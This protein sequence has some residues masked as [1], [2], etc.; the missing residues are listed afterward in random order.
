MNNTDVIVSINCMDDIKNITKNTKYINLCINKIS[1]DVIDYFLINGKDYSYS[2]FINNR[3]GYIYCGYDIFK[4]SESIIDG[5]ID[6]MKSNLSDIEKV[7]YIYISLGKFLCSD[8][9][10]DEDKNDRISFNDISTINNIWGSIYYGKTN[11]D[12]INKIFMYILKRIGI[13]SELIISGINGNTSCK[14]NIDNGYLITDLFS[15]IRYIQ[16]GFVTHYFDKYNN[17][18]DIDKKIGYIKEEYMDY[19]MDMI[20]DNIDYDDDD[21]LYEILSSTEKVLNINNIGVVEL[22]KIYRGIFDKYAINYDINI[23][24]LYV[25]NVDK[26]KEHFILFS[27]NDK[28]YSFNY[29]RGCF[30]KVDSDILYINIDS[31]KIGLYNGEYL[32]MNKGSVVL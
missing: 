24:N 14:V 10:L 31:N 18:K 2:E 6:N 20:F 25:Y 30:I 11:S 13:D 9:N 7:R 26:Y 1:V 27:Y 21:I 23:S 12:V 32:E 19:Y 16:G 5:I 4:K 15:D 29:K 3:Y 28:Y 17:D 8:I 22:S